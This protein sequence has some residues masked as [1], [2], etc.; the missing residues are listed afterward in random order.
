MLPVQAHLQ[1][2][3]HLR[4]RTPK[5]QESQRSVEQEG[6]EVAT[7]HHGNAA[8]EK[9]RSFAKTKKRSGLQWDARDGIVP[10]TEEGQPE[11]GKPRG[12][13]RWMLRGNL[14]QPRGNLRQLVESRHRSGNGSHPAT[15][16]AE[17]WRSRAQGL[18]PHSRLRSG[19]LDGKCEPRFVLIAQLAEQLERRSQDRSE[20]G[21][22]GGRKT[23]KAD[24]ENTPR[25]LRLPWGFSRLQ[26]IS[27]NRHQ[28]PD[29]R[30]SSTS[31]LSAS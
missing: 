17:R 25:G 28:T 5:A 22:A 1:R 11:T 7:F 26:K 19:V 15:G 3:I 12:N 23:V 29:N 9:H 14:R 2:S 21:R 8:R 27:D 31:G 6:G 18:R 30:Q 24:I 10:F 4:I 13:L 16:Y 20:G